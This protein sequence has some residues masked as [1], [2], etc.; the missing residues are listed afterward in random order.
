MLGSFSSSVPGINDDLSFGPSRGES[1][2]R[3]GGVLG[4]GNEDGAIENYNKALAL[5]PRRGDTLYNLGLIYKYRGAW[6]ES[7]EFNRRAREFEPKDEATL[8]NLAIAATALRD[9]GIA[10]EVWR[11][12][13]ISIAAGE[14]PIEGNRGW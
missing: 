4:D 12:L 3:G 7:F 10:R 2:Y 13:N 14:G 9:W 11:T 1:T 8:W 5:D 6:A